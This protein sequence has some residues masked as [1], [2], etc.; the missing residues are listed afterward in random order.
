MNIG[1]S[2][3]GYAELCVTTNFTFL[4][5]ASHPEEMVTT[6]AELGLTAIAITDRNS[7]A[8]VVRAYS[9]L[10]ILQRKAD[11]AVRIRSQH[12]IDSCSRQE[13]GA[14]QDIARPDAEHLPK[15]ITGCLLVL[16]DSA[17]EW[18]ALPT[19]MAAYRR[20]SRL[21][22]LG[23]R[24]AGKGECLLELQDLLDGCAGMILIALPGDGLEA[25]APDLHRM[26]R[27]FPA[28]VFLGAAPRYDGSDQDY[29]NA[30]ARLALRCSAPMVAV[31]DVLMHRAK[32]RQLADVLTCLREGCT[33]DSIGTRAL[34][35]SERRLKG[36]ADM[37][38][39]FH[40][41]PAALRRTLEI[42]ARCAFSLSELRY[43]YPDEIAEGAKARWTG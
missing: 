40:N 23:K 4:T 12:R 8:G 18:L 25:A 6:A 2:P 42:A 22:T 16:Q 13:I 19:D 29:L 39:L 20:L 5:G 36:Y 26:Q 27:R 32:R 9:A 14:P 43:Q 7:L 37:V 35:N 38:R 17:V 1:P 11:E 31:G 28:H 30:C 15:L 24:R 41:H 33:I 10:K 21:L 3:Q 34:P